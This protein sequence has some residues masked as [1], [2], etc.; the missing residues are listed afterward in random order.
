MRIH[1]TLLISLNGLNDFNE[2]V[3]Y[4]YIESAVHKL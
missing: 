4:G 3:G 2:I 1:V